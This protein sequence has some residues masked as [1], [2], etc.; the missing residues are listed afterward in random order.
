MRYLL[1]L[2]VGTSAVKAVLLETG[3]RLV[4]SVLE[5]YPLSTPRPGWSEQ[6]PEDMWQATI[7]AAASI[8]SKFNVAP[9]AIVGI[10]LSGQMHSSIFLDQNKQV[11]RPAI[12]WNDVR[13]SAQCR[14]IE[15]TMDRDLLRSEIC[16]PVLEGFTLPKVLWL[17]ENEPEN[18]GRLRHLVL[19]KDYIRFR[20]TGELQM[21]VSDAAGMIMMNVRKAKW[22]A[23]ILEAFDIDEAI[24]PP[25]IQSA[26]VAGTI[27]AEVARLTG[28]QEGTPV[29][30][31][32]AD[33]ACGAV[34]SGVVTPGR[35][36]VSLGTSGVILA[37]LAEPR[38]LEKGTVHM[39][40]SCI[41]GQFYMMGVTLSAGLSFSWFRNTVAPGESYD[42][43]TGRAREV[44]A[45]SRGLVFLPYLSGERTP[46]GDANA[47]G[48]FVGLSNTHGVADLTRA[49]LEG[50]AF[51]FRDSV[52]LLRQAGWN[53]SSLRAL[54]G[55]ARSPLWKE[56]IA[57]A[58]GLV[59]EEINIDEG[60]AL[61]A[62]ILAGVGAGV[63]KSAPEAVDS[64]IQVKSAVDP[65]PQW[66][67]TYEQLYQVYRDLYPALK[68]SFDNLTQFA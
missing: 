37:H 40:N 50:V 66:Q 24:L 41:P 10:G 26:D 30:G 5:E 51:A 25:I 12:L 55:G 60:P 19:P 54:G 18:Y 62:A 14:R 28:L 21:E 61:G 11:I 67:T 9:S 63:Y 42:S 45:G 34:G 38:L 22:S 65:N 33:N 23:P 17:K 31:G 2:D 16:N 36:M 53:G 52:E 7:K 68:G 6:N 13:T 64:I 56:I 44:P 4:G 8:V 39:F 27:T 59:L 49:V 48:S 20:L 35:G 57:S 58:T 32:G 46:H 29:V 1:G 47:R 3:G 15:N 43:L